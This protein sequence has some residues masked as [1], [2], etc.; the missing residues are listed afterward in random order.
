[1]DPK[2]LEIE[3]LRKEIAATKKETEEAKR[4]T[5]EAKRN[6]ESAVNLLFENRNRDV[7]PAAPQII[8]VQEIIQEMYMT[9]KWKL[10]KEF[11]NLS[12][13][14]LNQAIDEAKYFCEKIYHVFNVKEFNLL[15][16]F[17]KANI[18]YDP[19]EILMDMFL[20]NN[21][22]PHKSLIRLPL[23]ELNELMIDQLITLQDNDSDFDKDDFSNL[24]LYIKSYV[25]DERY[26]TLASSPPPSNGKR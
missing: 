21:W 4:K 7:Q 26:Q 13:E 2:D 24:C 5:K 15:T 10:N 6:A 8:K 17:I 3:K 9:R 25:P 16:T 12:L 22:S 19:K 14:Q 23:G 11:E 18:V 1:M 20:S